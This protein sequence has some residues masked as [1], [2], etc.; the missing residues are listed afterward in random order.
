MTKDL[1]TGSPLKLVIRFAFPLFL[2]MLLQQFY[3]IVDTIIVGRE[4]GVEA[5]A[6]VGSTGSLNF[7]VIGFCTGLSSGFSI[8]I[9]QQFGAKNERELRR[10]VANSLW[11]WLIYSAIITV[12]VCSFCDALLRLL[13]TPGDI[14]SYASDYLFV[15]FAGIP[16]T[17][18]YNTLA[19][20][21]RAVGDSRTPVLYLGLS[22]IL[23]IALDI[24]FLVVLHKG[25]VGA[26]LATVIAQ[27]FAG[28]LCLWRLRGYALLRLRPGD[29]I[30]SLLHMAELSRLAVPMGL[31]TV[32][33]AVGL[34]IVQGATNGLGT[35]VVAGV[36]AGLRINNFLQAPLDAVAQ[37]M[38]PYA[39]QNLGAGKSRRIRQGVG[40]ALL[41]GFVLSAVLLGVAVLFGREAAALFLTENDPMVITYAYEIATA[42]AWG[43][44]LLIILNVL[45]FTLQGMG[46]TFL[47]ILSGVMEMVAR[48]A[49]GLVLEP[50]FGFTGIRFAHPLAWLFGDIL[51][52]PAFFY[53]IRRVRSRESVGGELIRSEGDAI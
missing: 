9:A 35:K 16:C 17:I 33:T 29:G 43:Y 53:C 23:N 2:G 31:Q 42:M 3:N 10:Y 25:V 24:L 6:G 51:L 48:G 30:P 39:G 22:M 32:I 34:L 5:L 28:V 12:T 36:S 49:A 20:I 52:I 18:L 14:F 47:A 8:P 38:T 1:T 15:I 26:A 7:M 27:A 21:L 40:A 45:R 11:L 19:G 50:I 41:C 44:G 46:F 37:T 4:L 13:R